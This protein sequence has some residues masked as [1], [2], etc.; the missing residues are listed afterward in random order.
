MEPTGH[1]GLQHM[2]GEHDIDVFCQRRCLRDQPA[3]QRP[4]AQHAQTY[5][6]PELPCDALRYLQCEIGV[7]DG[8]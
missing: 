1:F 7:L 6:P 8:H 4:A 5:T 2:T 3:L